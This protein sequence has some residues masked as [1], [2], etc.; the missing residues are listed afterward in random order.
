MFD[1]VR[2]HQRANVQDAGADG[3]GE[4]TPLLFELSIVVPADGIDCQIEKAETSVRHRFMGSSQSS[5]CLPV[6]LGSWSARRESQ[7]QVGK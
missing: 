3:T 6:S 1:D 4:K 5:D 2:R 7:Y